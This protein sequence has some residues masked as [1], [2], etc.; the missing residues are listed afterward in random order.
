MNLGSDINLYSCWHFLNG[1]VHHFGTVHYKFWVYQDENLILGNQ[2]CCAL[3]DNKK[4]QA[5][6]VAKANHFWFL[7]S[8]KYKNKHLF[9][10]LKTK[11][12]QNYTLCMY[13][14]E[15]T[16]VVCSTYS[17]ISRNFAV[18]YSF[19]PK[20]PLYWLF[21]ESIIFDKENLYNLCLKQNIQN[22]SAHTYNHI[23][24]DF[25]LDIFTP[26]IQD[27]S[28]KFWCMFSIFKPFY[29]HIYNQSCFELK[30][31][32][33]SEVPSTSS[34]DKINRPSFKWFVRQHKSYLT[35]DVIMPALH[36]FIAEN[37]KFIQ[38]T[39]FYEKCWHVLEGLE[40]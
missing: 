34:L 5:S 26:F 33:L 17:D 40:H 28:V 24:V 16:A 7:Q 38:A 29:I 30:R 12:E 2:G 25:F 37:Q 22:N 9:E 23:F 20:I 35:I 39:N 3:S 4:V 21:H 31:K 14:F 11:R 6:L 18:I 36:S 27:S 10:R 19:W 15:W 32:L 1:L 8:I 13:W